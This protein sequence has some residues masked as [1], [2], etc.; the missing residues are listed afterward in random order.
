MTEEEIVQEVAEYFDTKEFRKCMNN[1]YMDENYV[2]V[3]ID[4][5]IGSEYS[6]L[7]LNKN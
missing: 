3:I 5:V 2:Y 6:V 1:F 7:K 4:D